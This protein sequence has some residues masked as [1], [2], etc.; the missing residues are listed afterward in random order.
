MYRLSVK[1]RILLQTSFSRPSQPR[2]QPRLRPTYESFRVALFQSIKFLTSRL[3]PV[4]LYA[5]RAITTSPTLQPGRWWPPAVRQSPLKCLQI[6]DIPLP[7]ARPSNFPT[8]E[9][10]PA[11]A[12]KKTSHTSKLE[13]SSCFLVDKLKLD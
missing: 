11:I 3:G 5:L 6:P 2:S 7:L 10:G 13:T 4:I 1:V 8:R 9:P 12:R